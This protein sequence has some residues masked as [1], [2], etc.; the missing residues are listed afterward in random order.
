MQLGNRRI[1][2]IAYYLLYL[3]HGDIQLKSKGGKRCFLS[4]QPM[5]L[6]NEASLAFTNKQP[7]YAGL[8]HFTNHLL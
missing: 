8:F 6:R 5:D 1:Y 4:I 3:T 2:T 7:G